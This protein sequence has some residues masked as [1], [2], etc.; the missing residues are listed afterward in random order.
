MLPTEVTAPGRVVV[1]SDTL[2]GGYAAALCLRSATRVLQLIHEED[3]NPDRAAG[4]TVYEATREGAP[5]QQLLQPGQTLGVHCMHFYGNSNITNSQLVARR[6]RDAVC[7]AVRDA[8]GVRPAPPDGAPDLPLVFQM[9]DDRLQ[10]FRDLGGGSLHRRGYRSGA[11]MHKAALNEAAAAGLLLLAGW[12]QHSQQEGAVLADPM[13]GSGTLLIEAALIATGTPPG[14]LRSR[15]PFEAW[16]DHDAPVRSEWRAV[17]QAAQQRAEQGWAD[18]EAR[19]GQLLGND[20]HEGALRLAHQS[21]EAAG[22]SDLIRLSNRPCGSWQPVATPRL[23]VCNPPW[24]RRLL[25]EEQQQQQQQ[26]SSSRGGDGWGRDGGSGRDSRRGGQ[27]QQQQWEDEG[28]YDDEEDEELAET[29]QQLA[30]FLKQQCPGAEAWV[31]S[32]SRDVTQHLGMRS[33]KKRSLS[34][35]GVKTAW[36]KYEYWREAAG[37]Q[38]SLRKLQGRGAFK[39]AKQTALEESFT[40]PSSRIDAA[41][42]PRRQIGH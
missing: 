40:V 6:V 10:L 25:G 7:D 30:S 35:G 22:V 15:W 16:H 17:R 19:G 31:L 37:Q 18:W 9:L 29:W 39:N 8:R 21:A 42:L 5:W 20:L 3:L 23:V 24:G 12:Q 1:P 26:Y 14:L 41:L 27:R 34:I 4:D 28:A 38:Q 36:L 33:S 11:A 13:C 32:G 2:A